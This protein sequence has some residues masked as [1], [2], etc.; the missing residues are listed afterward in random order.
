MPKANG[1]YLGREAILKCVDLK[2]EDVDCPE[3]EGR[4]RV[5]ELT[6]LE[7]NEMGAEFQGGASVPKDFYPVMAAKV[8][9]DANGH[10]V[11]TDKDIE[12]LGG[13]SF[14]PIQRVVDV[15]IK[16][17]GMAEDEAEEVGKASETTESAASPSG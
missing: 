1:G 2:Y 16:L 11:F 9:V 15:C 10:R 17:S 12:A 4:L 13:K 3:W 6:A 14:E 8:I 5:R 7:R